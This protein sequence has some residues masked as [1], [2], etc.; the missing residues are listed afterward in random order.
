MIQGSCCERIPALPVMIPAWL[1]VKIRGWLAERI[2]DWRELRTT[3]ATTIGH[4]FL[5]TTISTASISTAST[6]RT[7]MCCHGRTRCPKRDRLQ[8]IRRLRRCTL[9]ASQKT[10][11]AMVVVHGKKVDI[12]ALSRLERALAAPA[13]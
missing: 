1:L 13:I 8:S 9:R 7:L 11:V 5:S 3:G 10:K 6:G 2:L 12:V 4:F